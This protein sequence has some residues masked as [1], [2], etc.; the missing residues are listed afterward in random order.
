MKAANRIP[1]SCLHAV[2]K[3]LIIFINGN[4]VLLLRPN[5]HSRAG[6]FLLI[7]TF[8]AGV[9]TLNAVAHA[10]EGPEL[11]LDVSALVQDIHSTREVATD[12]EA[13]LAG[14]LQ[15]VE[16]QTDALKKAGCTPEKTSSQCLAMKK[17]LRE[18]YMGVL[19]SVEQR[20]PALKRSVNRVVTSIEERMGRQAG[21]SASDVQSELIA[22]S[23]DQSGSAVKPKLRLQGVSGS[24]LSESLGR[25]QGLV[26][27]SGMSGVSMQTMQNDLYLDMRDSLRILEN[28]DAAIQNTRIITAVQM[29]DM[30][31]S[32]EQMSVAQEAQGFIL[33][34]QDNTV[35]WLNDPD[36]NTSEDNEADFKSDLEL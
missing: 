36:M 26:S 19:D 6:L 8:T 20:L 11:S 3:R 32:D 14:T 7:Y 12:V 34:R 27:T 29:G 4:C 13:S 30:S 18:K 23:G 17:V 21:V 33:G 22:A 9:L 28:L 15:S 2:V 24:R 35:N 25:L 1:N 16:Q 10:Q 31:I 5:Y